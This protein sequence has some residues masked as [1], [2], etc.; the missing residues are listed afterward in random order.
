MKKLRLDL[1]ALD[2]QSFATLRVDDGRGTVRG[3]DSG[4]LAES[5]SQV[6]SCNPSCH[7][8]ESGDCAFSQPNGGCLTYPISCGDCYS[9]FASWCDETCAV[10]ATC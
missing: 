1:D 7:P 10:H 4:D 6:Q 5:D 3:A 2:V 9:G 8:C